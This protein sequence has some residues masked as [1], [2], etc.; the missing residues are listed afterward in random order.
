M[1]EARESSPR[2]SIV[3]CGD[4]AQSKERAAALLGQIGFDPVDAGPL[5]I[6][7]LA[8]PFGMLATALAYGH[9]EA[10][11]WVYHFS[12]LE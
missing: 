3:Y 2:P 4:H 9:E 8:E 11:K 6:A 1:F 10:P 12:R 7:R 5:R